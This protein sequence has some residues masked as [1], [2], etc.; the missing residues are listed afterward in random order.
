[1]TYV[2]LPH[3]LSINYLQLLDVLVQPSATVTDKTVATGRAVA[4]R[5]IAHLNSA[6]LS[7]QLLYLTHPPHVLATA[8]IYLA[9]REVE[10]KLPE[11]EWWL[12]FD[13][14]REELGFVVVALLSLEGWV[15]A[16]MEKWGG[17]GKDGQG[18][19]KGIWDSLTAEGVARAVERER[20]NG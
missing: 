11:E 12:V 17:S 3:S 5:T 16:E 1:M 7:P 20:V 4:A 14:D 13:T 6:L 15:S 18:V 19:G 9:A 2:A 10:C 8:A